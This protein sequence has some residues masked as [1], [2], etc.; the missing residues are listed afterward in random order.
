[1]A[2]AAEGLIA[3]RAALLLRCQD[4]RERRARTAAAG[5]A[6]ARDAARAR[7]EAAGAERDAQARR[8]AEALRAGYDRLAG[9]VVD[10]AAVAALRA[11]ETAWQAEA[12]RL[13]LAEDAAAAALD[14]AETGL[15]AARAA[16]EAEARRTCRR[17]RLAEDTAA[18]HR[19]VLDAAEEAERDEAASSPAEAA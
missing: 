17:A 5:A 13:R 12:E 15:T 9:R 1:M 11:A 14:A 8:R 19:R 4:A 18:R 2:G 10:A 16:M 7:R 3:R 6:R